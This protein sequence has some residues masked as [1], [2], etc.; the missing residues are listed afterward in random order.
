MTIHATHSLDILQAQPLLTRRGFSAMLAEAA[1]EAGASGYLVARIEPEGSAV[2]AALVASDWSFDA[3]QDL[4]P[5][6]LSLI[7]ASPF[8]RVPGLPAR[9]WDAADFMATCAETAS[10]LMDHGHRFLA[11]QRL[12]MDSR[13]FLLLLSAPAAFRPAAAA[14]AQMRALYALSLHAEASSQMTHAGDDRLSARERQCLSWVSEGKTSDEIALIMGLSVSTVN[15][16]L[17]TAMQKIGAPNRAMAM[18]TAI[19][20]G[21]I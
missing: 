20:K 4:G 2:P 1:R 10:A 3:T 8:T 6:A 17:G 9:C 11:S 16:H 5:A 14:A 12:R 19:R 13:R 15:G 21:L 7:A 18:A